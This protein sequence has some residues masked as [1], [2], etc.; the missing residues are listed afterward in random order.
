M[1]FTKEWY[2]IHSHHRGMLNK[3]GPN[4]GKNFSKEWRKN[5]SKSRIKKGVAKGNK[6]PNWKGGKMIIDGYIYIWKPNHPNA[7]NYGYVLEHR[8]IMEKHLGRLL[9]SKEVVHHINKIKTDNKIKNLKL[10]KS[11]GKHTS[12]EHS[13]KDKRGRFIAC[14]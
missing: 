11:A 2:K 9:N 4:K 14:S 6:N 10:Y 3:V 1:V 13:K 7:T 8:L 5:I 12:K